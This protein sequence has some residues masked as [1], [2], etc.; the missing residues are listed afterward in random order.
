M[1]TRHKRTLKKLLLPVIALCM[2]TAAMALGSSSNGRSEE[3]GVGLYFDY[4]FS[5]V[6]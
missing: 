5:F 6:W 1:P 2:M 3:S 4:Y